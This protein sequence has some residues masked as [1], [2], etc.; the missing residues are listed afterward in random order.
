M[1]TSKQRFVLAVLLF[2]A[3][4]AFAQQQSARITGTVFDDAR[5]PL[6]GASVAVAN[7]TRGVSTSSDGKDVLRFKILSDEDL[8]LSAQ[9]EA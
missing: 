8:R 6:V 9:E 7:T 5:K 3:S 1:I 2:A 4:F